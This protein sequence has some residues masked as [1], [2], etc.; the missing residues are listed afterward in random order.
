[1]A[2]CQSL[3]RRW[4]DQPGLEQ[5]LREELLSIEGQEDQ[6]SDRFYR[7]LAFGTGGLRGRMGAGTNRM[8]VY[9]VLR[10]TKG[11][12]KY[13]GQ[14]SDLPSCAIAYD[15]REN[16]RRFAQV[17]AAALAEKGVRVYLYGELA[18]TPMCSFA[19][20]Y[21]KCDGGIVI[22]AS[23]N[24]REY[25]GYKVYDKHGCQ[26][27]D[28]IAAEISQLIARQQDLVSRLPDYE[29]QLEKGMIRL[30]ARDVWQ[31]YQQAVLGLSVMTPTTPLKVVYSP[32]HGTGNRPVRQ[33]LGSLPNLQ[34]SVVAEQEQPDGSF[35]TVL[36]PNP[37]YP[38][39]MELAARQMLQTQADICLVTDPD[40]DRLGVGVRIRDQVDYL[41]GNELGVLLL[42]FICQA[43]QAAGSM[44]DSPLAVTTIVTTPMAAA[45][46]DA[47]GVQLQLVLTGFKYIG[48][49]INRLKREGQEGRYILGFEE[50]YGYLS[51]THVRDK[52]AVNAALLVC[53]MASYYLGQRQNLREAYRALQAAYGVYESGLLSFTFEGEQGQAELA[54]VMEGL[55]REEAPAGY[56]VEEKRDYGT[57]LD[58]LP[59]SD[60]LLFRLEGDRTLIARPSG[61]EPLLKLY[62]HVRQ[63]EGEDALQKLDQL[64]LAAASLIDRLRR[65]A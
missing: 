29:Q 61:T 15:S 2:D 10:A 3:Y 19:V 22:T 57:G 11:L 58:G 9:T 64:R 38:Q 47:F 14:K 59:P 65:E 54:R 8:N 17:A 35:P 4:L 45:V 6:I 31:A 34:V 63:G 12:A 56:A 46:A 41:T 13:L 37:E 44:P 18:P 20:R 43:R 53:E 28:E 60:V 30:I 42:H 52:D 55:R 1:M 51:G 62:L 50:S 48:A 40:C 5:A 21:L 16:S 27:T 26:I 25:N 36:K 39:A 32:L 23:H 33:V 49:T 7:G 24:A